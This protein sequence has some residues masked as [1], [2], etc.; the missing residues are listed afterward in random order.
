M[1]YFAHGYQYCDRPYFLAGTAV[2]DWMNVV[3]R[4]IRPRAAIAKKLLESESEDWRE[5]AAGI[6]QHHYDDRWFHQTR[7]FMELTLQFTGR[8]R[9]HLPE[10]EGFRTGF[11]G[12][13]LVELLL[14][15]EL[16]KRHPGQLDV[17]YE[18]LEA[19]NARR[20]AEGVSEMT[21]KDASNLQ[22]MIQRFC[23]VR[24]LADYAEDQRLLWRLN[25]V[26]QRVQL[27]ELP[28]DIVSVFPAA[29]QEVAARFDELL[30]AP[31]E[32]DS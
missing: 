17:Y 6:I 8:I 19:V 18:T 20:V 32:S 15:A 14:D 4:S 27:P 31:D 10:D 7:A 26:M 22:W 12:H 11:L 1:N 16:A 3:D 2:P 23:V 25:G 21:G 5:L 28:S 24:F 13:I 9:A 30:T 29:R